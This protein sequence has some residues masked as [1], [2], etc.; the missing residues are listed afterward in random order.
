MPTLI[1]EDGTGLANANSYISLAAANTYFANNAI[2]AWE[3]LD[4]NDDKI[5]LLIRAQQYMS[6][7]YGLLWAAYRSTGTQRLDWPR[8]GVEKPLAFR[9]YPDQPYPGV[10]Q[11]NEI[12]FQIGE[13]QAEIALRINLNDG[14]DLDIDLGPLVVREKVGPIETQYAEGTRQ[15]T[16]Y[17]S[18]DAMLMPFLKSQNQFAIYRG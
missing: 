4:D 6:R 16:V 9:P 8:Y 2:L 3:A 15:Q 17:Q 10:Y 11:P 1:V 14:S 13:A 12:P 18:V 5:P 7:T